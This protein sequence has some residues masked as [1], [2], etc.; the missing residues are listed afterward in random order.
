[1]TTLQLELF[2]VVLFI[3]FIIKLYFRKKYKVIFVVN[4]QSPRS[5]EQNTARHVFFKKMRLDFTPQEGQKFMF[6]S[7]HCSTNQVILTISKNVYWNTAEKYFRAQFKDV[8][9]EKLSDYFEKD[10][11]KY[12]GFV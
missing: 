9:V 7:E 3:L 10:V 12:N 1:M 2:L 5:G 8:D 11:L 4:I 6:A